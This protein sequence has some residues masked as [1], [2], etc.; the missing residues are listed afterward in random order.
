MISII[1][2]LLG[3]GVWA[4]VAA[5]GF[6]IL[7]NV[8]TR[9]LVPIWILAGLGTMTKF[10]F[11]NMGIGIILSSFAGASLVGII[12]IYAAKKYYGP[13]LVFSIPSVIPMV[14]GVFAYNMMLGFM[15]LSS[16]MSHEEYIQ[17]LSL[18][19]NNGLKALFIIMGL[20][21]GVALP[22]LIARKESFKHIEHNQN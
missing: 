20:A 3:K 8:P 22:M 18:T 5:I 21:T 2:D 10:V 9:A 12:G 15:D 6:A 7:F 14:P 13:P 16:T 4:G 19:T 17:V 1:L 11:I